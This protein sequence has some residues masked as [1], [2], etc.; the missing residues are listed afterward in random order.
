MAKKRVQICGWW[1]SA[2]LGDRYQ[3]LA[4]AKHF[5]A[6][7]IDFDAMGYHSTGKG[8]FVEKYP[9]VPEIKKLKIYDPD[10]ENI[11]DCIVA[12]T[13]SLSSY[14][15]STA[16]LRAIVEKNSRFHRLVVWGGFQ[17]VSFDSLAYSVDEWSWLADPRV[18]FIARSVGDLECLRILAGN[19]A[20]GVLGGD[21]MCNWIPAFYHQQ[22][23]MDD[24]M[25]LVMSQ[26]CMEKCPEVGRELLDIAQRCN[27]KVGCFDGYQ[28]RELIA[29]HR[30]T[31]LRSPL[32]FL[33]WLRGVGG[34]VAVRLH[35]AI[36]SSVIFVPTVAIGT[37]EKFSSVGLSCLDDRV[38][39]PVQLG[40]QRA[41]GMMGGNDLSVARDY[42]ELSRKTLN[43]LVTLLGLS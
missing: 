7:G 34:L 33:D 39:F 20:I 27:W 11:A 1:G 8:Y 15:Y 23:S 24:P 26:P 43:E 22:L 30:A 12:V 5:K 40:L 41:L 9:D 4:I 31:H 35:A 32:V 10:P 18:F 3:P 14:S 6:I 13:G 16:L 2:N 17:D 42:L 28:D 36:L 29:R 25:A 19:S 37:N 21:P 38:L